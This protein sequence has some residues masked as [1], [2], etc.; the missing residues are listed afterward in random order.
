MSQRTWSSF[1]RGL[2]AWNDGDY[3]AIVEMCH[4]GVEWTFSDRLPDA[5]GE[6]RGKASVRTFFERF[7]GDWSDISIHP[8]RIEDPGPHVVANSTSWRGDA[9]ASR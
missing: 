4:P 5:T 6:I 3:E 8:E 1:R 9:T 2:A 7:T